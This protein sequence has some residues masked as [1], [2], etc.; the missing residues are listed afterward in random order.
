MC[1]P[2][3]VAHPSTVHKGDATANIFFVFPELAHI[4]KIFSRFIIH[5]I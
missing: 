2:I 4:Y 1:L 3:K 5:E